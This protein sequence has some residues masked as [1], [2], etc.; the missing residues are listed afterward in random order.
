MTSWFKNQGVTNQLQ[1][2][3]LQ[4]ASDYLRGINLPVVTI[5]TTYIVNARHFG[6][7]AFDGSY[8]FF[9]QF[10]KFVSCNPRILSYLIFYPSIKSS[11][12]SI[13][14]SITLSITLCRSYK[15]DYNKTLWID[16]VGDVTPI[17]NKPHDAFHARALVLYISCAIQNIG[18]KRIVWILY[19]RLADVLQRDLRRQDTRILN[20]NAVIVDGDAYSQIIPII[21][22]MT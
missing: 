19:V 5:S 9:T 2:L 21:L 16:R 22:T 20:L 18:N 14:L 3:F 12:L 6:D 17:S 10:S 13:I 7:M 8:S 15:S 1:L 4:F 11:I